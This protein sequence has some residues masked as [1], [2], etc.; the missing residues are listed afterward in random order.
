MTGLLLAAAVALA[1][2]DPTPAADWPQWLGPKRDNTS[3]ETVRPWTDPPKVVWSAKCGPG[4]STPVVAGGKVFVHARVKGKDAEEL[5]ALAAADGTELWRAGYPRAP[6]SSVLNTGP[7]ATP[8][9]AGNKVY[10]FGITGVLSCFAADTGS[11]VWQVDCGK[12]LGLRVPRFGVTCSPL[13]VG[14]RVIVAVGGAGR[15]VVGFDA[16]TGEVKWKALDESAGTA[17][18]VLL[19]ARPGRLPDV[20]FMTTLRLV[21]LDPLDGTVAWE[22]PLAFQ[23]GGTAPTPLVSNDLILTTTTSNGTTAVRLKPGAGD[24]PPAGEQVWQAAGVKGYFSSGVVAAPDAAYLVSNVLE[25]VPR[26]DLACVDLRTGT[27]H[28][29]REGLGYFH[30]GLVRTG[31][32]K[33]LMVDDLGTLRLAEAS[34]A[35][36]KELCKAK[37]CDGSMV[38]PALAGGRLFVR[39]DKGVHCIDLR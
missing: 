24:E 9:V 32:G 26:A 2:A 6:Y 25:P 10:T 27:Q 37:V 39:D 22:H 1:P 20:V 35:G 18:P 7:Q 28:W 8:A 23:P 30:F 19:A 13:V 11:R 15:A 34:P 29:K 3:P 31:D 14:S 33:L 12:V 38:A 17:S 5:V 36:Y 4:F 16:D 21:G